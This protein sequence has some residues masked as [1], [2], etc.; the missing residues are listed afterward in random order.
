MNQLLPGRRVLRL[1]RRRRRARRR[2]LVAAGAVLALAASMLAATVSQATTT[3]TPAGPLV[4]DDTITFDED[5]GGRVINNNT[6]NGTSTVVSGASLLLATGCLGDNPDP[7]GPPG[8]STGAAPAGSRNRTPRSV[9]TVT[10][11][12]GDVIYKGMSPVLNLAGAPADPQPAPADLNYRGGKWSTGPIT[13]AG[14]PPGT[15]TVTTQNQDTVWSHTSLQ[16]TACN[17]GTTTF[18]VTTQV[19]TFEYRPWQVQFHDVLG[20]GNVKMNVF[21]PAPPEFAFDVDGK[22]SPILDGTG[23]MTFYAAPD[24]PAFLPANPLDCANDASGCVPKGATEC[25]PSTGCTPR[26][27]LIRHNVANTEQLDG[28]FD[29]DTKAFV[30]YA[31]VGGRTRVLVSGGTQVD[32]VIVGALGSAFKA[33]SAHGVDLA[34]LLASRVDVNVESKGFTDTYSVGVLDLLSIARVEDG[35][36]TGV[37]ITAPLVLNAGLQVY[38]KI[39]IAQ[40]EL[41]EGLGSGNL[42]EVTGL[43][44]LPA[45][46]DTGNGVVSLLAPP[47]KLI[48][49]K[50]GPGGSHLAGALNASTDTGE[51]NGLPAWVPVYSGA[52]LVADKGI[53]FVGSAT[54]ANSETC[55]LGFCSGLALV[56]G[57]GVALY[58]KNPL[59]VGLGD[60]PYLVK[61]QPAPLVGLMTTVDGT[62]GPTLEQVLADPTVQALLATIDPVLQP[63]VDEALDAVGV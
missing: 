41:G 26:L 19:Q 35:G 16:L 29:L 20:K 6:T 47:G 17:T 21:A 13:L 63:L 46:P 24:A 52:A 5:T 54:V 33:A 50:G 59:P 51:P 57:S 15:Y 36:P 48:H 9:I 10:D 55:L 40:K 11:P 28:V 1:E 25:D 23:R 7:W 38:I 37:Q 12:N 53:E 32:P 58:G 8:P 49:V 61:N 62:A 14:H 43:G 3:S 39:W 27:V 56:A 42:L 60:I 45:V 4:R 31:K 34:A 2:R 44:T 30:A 18:P 22:H